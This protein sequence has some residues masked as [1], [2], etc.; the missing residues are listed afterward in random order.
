MRQRLLGVLGALC[1]AAGASGQS[2]LLDQH[3]AP[4]DEGVLRREAEVYRQHLFT[5]A[6]PLFEG[7]APGT[8]GNRVAASY[9][10]LE[11]RRLG[12]EPAFPAEGAEPGSPRTTYRQAFDP[13][14]ARAPVGRA[15][16]PR[17]A[18][19]Y[20]EGDARVSLT[21]GT[22][23]KI[24]GYSGDGA[25]TG[26]LAFA[27][28]SIEEGEDDYTSYPRGK[29]LEG[30]VAI[31]LRFEPMTAEGRSK[32]A[33]TGWTVSAAL[34]PKLRAAAEAGATAIILVNPPGAQ[35]PRVGEVAGLEL[36]T[37]PLRVPVVMMTQDAA[38]ALVKAAD[39]QGRSLADLRALADAD[40]GVID[41]PKAPVTLDVKV[42]RAST[43]TDN[44]GAILPGRGALADEWIIIGSHYDH[45]GYGQVGARP[46]NNGK[47][48]P[49]ADDNASGTTGNLLAAARLTDA[50]AQG[51]GDARSILFLWFSA[52]ESGLE[53]ARHFADN[54]IMD[55]R[56][57]SLMLNM[58]MIGRLRERRVEVG[59][60]GT[61]V[62]LQEWLQ[63]YWDS[64]GLEV[65]PIRMGASNSDHFAFHLKDVPN[66]FFFTGLHREYHTPADVAELVNV[67]GAVQIADLVSRVALDAAQRP[68]KF[69]FDSGRERAADADE[70]PPAPRTGLRVRF[71]I[72]P[73]D[74][75][76]EDGV[77]VGD[78]TGPDTPA[79]KAGLKAGDRI[80]RWNGEKV[81]TIE[82]WMG[83]MA[84]N[85][86]GD[87]V[88][89]VFVR[90][91]AE[92]TTKATLVAG[93]RPRPQ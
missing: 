56:K 19:E 24:L 57:V 9:L 12:L 69:E 48:H 76:G 61:G 16:L 1:L 78:T 25:V 67:E 59:G 17:K 29:M 63:P 5:L 88:E 70:P 77:L 83:L 89:I 62:G 37:R 64:S 52:E 49:G 38:D 34:D 4:T 86:P 82:Q 60:V 93:G 22:D 13:R 53:G 23:F 33:E 27:G 54:P 66:L 30:K 71:G 18:F 43:R 35:D 2:L 85:N 79:A 31:V 90:E 47:I 91:G 8:L 87:V 51:E 46:E 74:Y 28:Y 73:G 10:E 32:W 65:K 26:P 41:L 11:L 39:A 84:K 80:T 15:K 72:M 68:E 50:Y 75:A 92:Q 42:E 44:V 6:D 7:R 3:L 36:G 58:D 20:G 40:G 45:V 81:T 14:G 55:L 21:H